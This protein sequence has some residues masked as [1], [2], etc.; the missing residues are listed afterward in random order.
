MKNSAGS[1]VLRQQQQQQQ[2]Q[3]NETDEDDSSGYHTKIW[4]N[5]AITP[6]GDEEMGTGPYLPAWQRR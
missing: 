3:A 5:G 1:L 6:K 4:S 2:Q